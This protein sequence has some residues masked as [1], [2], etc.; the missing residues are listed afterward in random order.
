MA[1]SDAPDGTMW[2]Q[3]ISVVVDTP[4]PPE[5][6]N[7]TP[8]GGV[9]RLAT[10]STSYQTIKTWTIAPGKVGELRFVEMDSTYYD[11]TR[12]KLVIGATTFF[13]DLELGGSLSLD[14]GALKLAAGSVVTLSAKSS[15]LTAIVAWGDII[16]KEIG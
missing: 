12:F 11:K 8:A 2:V 13:T 15:D 1:I 4:I 9:A 14:F 10:A 7:E 5:P 6:A 16:G 3:V